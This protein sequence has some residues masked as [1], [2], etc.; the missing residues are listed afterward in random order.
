MLDPAHVAGVGMIRFG[1]YPATV[2]L[3][4]M[5]AR[6]VMYSAA[7]LPVNGSLLSSAWMASRSLMWRTTARAG[8][9]RSGRPGS[10]CRP[11]STMWCW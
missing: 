5:A 7:R 9:P 11:D 1:K 3:E 6:A 10:L 8:L 4:R 2:T